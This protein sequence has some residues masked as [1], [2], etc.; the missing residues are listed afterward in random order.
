VARLDGVTRNEQWRALVLSTFALT[1]CFAVWTISSIIGP[2]I[3]TELGLS[4]SQFGLLVA[5]P[6]LMGSVSRIFLGIRTEQFG[7][8]LMFPL[9]MLIT[10]LCVWLMTSAQWYPV[11]LLAALG[12]GLAGGSFI[13]GSPTRSAGSRPNVRARRSE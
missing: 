5:T 13:I 3:K 10:S 7:G 8:R 6:I 1:V 4:E 2:R 9:K 11:F 12:L